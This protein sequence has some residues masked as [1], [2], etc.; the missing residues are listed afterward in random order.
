MQILVAEPVGDITDRQQQVHQ[1]EQPADIAQMELDGQEGCNDSKQI[2]PQNDR[3]PF[4]LLRMGLQQAGDQVAA[5]EEH[6][7]IEHN[8]NH[9]GDIVLGRIVM[10]HLLQSRDRHRQRDA[11]QI[12]HAVK[13]PDIGFDEPILQEGSLGETIGQDERHR[14]DQKQSVKLVEIRPYRH[15]MIVNPARLVNQVKPDIH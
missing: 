15:N 1:T 13:E 3:I 2:Y 7:E 4:P 12:S 5:A 9:N 14:S 10:R 6:H 11:Y 8:Q